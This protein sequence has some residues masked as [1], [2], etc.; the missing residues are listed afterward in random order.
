MT[1]S[2]I[3]ALCYHLVCALSVMYRKSGV[4]D[5]QIGLTASI[6]MSK[7]TGMFVKIDPQLIS[8]LLDYN[9]L[10]NVAILQSPLTCL[11]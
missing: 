10:L 8:D 4:L 2:H 9:V 7:S 3:P 11:P 5:M 1:L 6:N